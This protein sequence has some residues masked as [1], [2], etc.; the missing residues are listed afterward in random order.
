MKVK[1]WIL[2]LGL[3]LFLFSGCQKAEPLSRE[4]FLLGS[5]VK[6]T[7]HDGNK[8]KALERAFQRIEEL[9]HQLD[10]NADDAAI[11][12]INQQAGK[13]PVEIPADI[14]SFLQICQRYSAQYPGFDFTIG[15]ITTLWGIGSEKARKP[16]DEEIA[17]ALRY[18]DH[19]KVR[20]DD[21]K[22]TV[23]LPEKGMGIDVGA[24][25]KGFVADEVVKVLRS[26]GVTSGNLDFGG[27]LYLLGKKNGQ[28][29]EVGI[30]DP[31]DINKLLKEVAVTNHSVVTSGIYQRYFKAEGQWYH[32]LF[33]PKTGYP[34]AGDLAS[35]TILSKS[36]LEADI[37][38]T[39][40]FVYKSNEALKVL[41]AKEIA[42]ILVSRDNHMITTKQLKINEA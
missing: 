38:A 9:H 23:F 35:V 25:A 27:N 6:V 7:V 22:R 33:D 28:P 24:A 42:A 11:A 12:K 26:E 3:S 4:A 31:R 39:A 14:Y 16:T 19:R 21:E 13:G 10:P 1:I 40:M 8:E 36:S 29:W 5:Y 18:V 2:L 20:F 37:L 15:P 17:E 34:F 32:H 30:Q 41:E